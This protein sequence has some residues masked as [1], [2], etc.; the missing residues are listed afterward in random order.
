[1]GDRGNIVV[2]HGEGQYIHLYTHW[3]GSELERILR[4]VI[5]E[6]DS[7]DDETY[8]T[9]LIVDAMIDVGHHDPVGISARAQDNERPV[10]LV[11]PSKRTVTKWPVSRYDA[12]NKQPPGDDET[13]MA[14][15]TFEEFVR[16]GKR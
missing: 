13:P 5:A 12:W 10:L 2:K 1:M 11:D 9:G 6:W 8:L 4:G 15:W 16:A 14:S 7:L 3:H